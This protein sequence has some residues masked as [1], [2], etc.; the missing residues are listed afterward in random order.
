MTTQTQVANQIAKAANLQVEEIFTAGGWTN[1]EVMAFRL[2]VAHW[3]A[4]ANRAYLLERPGFETVVKLYDAAI[5]ETTQ[6]GRMF[7][8]A[9]EGKQTMQK[10]CKLRD[11]LVKLVGSQS[12]DDYGIFDLAFRT[13]TQT[14]LLALWHHMKNNVGKE[15]ADAVVT[16]VNNAIQT[17]VNAEL[18]IANA[19]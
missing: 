10:A 14:Q 16:P 17:A 7:M 9:P 1:N 5:A 19:A 3:F 6:V 8:E 18:E 15:A 4:K 11:A 12:E 13:I 2:V